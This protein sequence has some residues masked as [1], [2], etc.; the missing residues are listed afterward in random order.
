MT[1]D[2]LNLIEDR[3]GKRARVKAKERAI[4]VGIDLTYP[5]E[6]EALWT[7]DES[8]K[9]LASLAETAGVKI[10]DRIVQRRSKPDPKFYIGKGKVDEIKELTRDRGAHVILF[11]DELRPAQARNLEENIGAKIVDR[12]QLIMDIFAQR[13]QTKEAKLQVELAQYEYL[14]PRLRGWG[15]SLERQAGGIGTRGPGQTR[16]ARDREKVQRRID[17]IR[18]KLKEAEKE[19]D[20]RRKRRLESNLPIVALIGYTNTG[21]TTLLNSLTGSE[22]FK[23]DKLFATLDPLT[24]KFELPDRRKV[25][26]TDTVGLIRK[27]PH[28]LI[29]AFKST[30]KSARSADLL[31]NLMDAT[32]EK[33]EARW[34]TVNSILNEEIF[35]ED[36][37]RPPMINVINKIDLLVPGK[38]IESLTSGIENSVA[39][40]AKE[41]DN[42]AELKDLIARELGDEVKEIKLHLP[43]DKAE[44]LDWLH[45]NGEVKE[46][47]Y[48]G[49]EIYIVGKIEQHLLTEL[50]YELTD[51]ELEVA[52]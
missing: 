14:L 18:A 30:L 4:L 50:E 36:Q 17:S 43:Y 8:L 52:T 10:A 1:N 48:K 6:E 25:L 7:T 35:D 51:G 32:Q 13:A 40:S 22:G 49:E 28:Q 34:Q 24:R 37:K 44:I 19:L 16:L 21:K 45:N 27:L 26:V 5:Q 2:E 3:I 39:I 23:E 41:G 29:P 15:E 11:N 38:E 42:L 31:L 46:E 33:L 20:V 12:P 47:E 9:E